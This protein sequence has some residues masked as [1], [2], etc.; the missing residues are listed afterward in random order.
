[1]YMSVFIYVNVC[2]SG[3]IYNSMFVV[4][5]LFISLCDCGWIQIILFV[6]VSLYIKINLCVCVYVKVCV[7]L[8]LLKSVFCVKVSLF[9]FRC[10]CLSLCTSLCLFLQYFV[11]GSNNKSVYLTFCIFLFVSAYKQG[12]VYLYV[13]LY[14]SMFL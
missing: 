2:A 6:S 10:V 12:A 3:S 9:M 1:M 5:C 4:V 7:C 11:Y 13:H 8:S 14:V